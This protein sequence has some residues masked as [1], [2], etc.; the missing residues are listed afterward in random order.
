MLTQPSRKAKQ[1]CKLKDIHKTA[2]KMSAVRQSPSEII[3]RGLHSCTTTKISRWG[4][5]SRENSRL[6][7]YLYDQQQ[8]IQ[9]Y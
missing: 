9:K 1:W 7:F 2:I 8:M 6:M 3:T 5:D 4:E